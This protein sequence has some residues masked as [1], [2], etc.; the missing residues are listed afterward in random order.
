MHLVELVALHLEAYYNS[1]AVPVTAVSNA[2]PI[3]RLHDASRIA[4]DPVDRVLR[5]RLA[6]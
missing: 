2:N 1:H 5:Y 4:R 6:R 3:A